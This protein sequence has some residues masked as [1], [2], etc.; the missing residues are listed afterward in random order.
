MEF[1]I[2]A[3]KC[4]NRHGVAALIEG[5]GRPLVEFESLLM[6]IQSGEVNAVVLTGGYQ[7]PWL[8]AEQVDLLSQLE[9]LVRVD[10]LDQELSHGCGDYL[11]P[12]A[13]WVEKTGS[14]VNHDRFLQGTHRVVRAPGDAR[15]EGR[16]FWELAGR[17]RLYHAGDVLEELAGK[18]AFF[19]PCAEGVVGELGVSLRG[20]EEP[21][22]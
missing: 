22:T 8:T 3:E 16:I 6:Q 4:P 21:V 2:R 10:I 13:A 9:L 18:M 1:T 15:S 19:A 17:E 11:L 12:G 14:Y 7:F 20:Q 5:W